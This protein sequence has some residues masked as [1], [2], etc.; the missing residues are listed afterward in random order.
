MNGRSLTA[1]LVKFL[2]FVLVTVLATGVLLLTIAN[3]SF[4]P[5]QTY[6]ARFTDVT[7][8]AEGDDVRI[9]G[10][11]VGEVNGIRV[12]EHRLAEVSFTVSE[13]R[14]PSSVTAA[15][16][17]RNLIGQRYVSLEQ[18]AGAVDEYL[19]PGK[20]IPVERTKP[21]LDLNVLL[22]GFKPLFQALSPKDVNTL[23]FEIIQVLQ[24][25][26]GTVE[27]L[28]AHTA[29]LTK[30]IAAKDEVIGQV[31]GNL[32]KVLETVNARDQELTGLV[33]QLQELVSGLAEDRDS[34]GGAISAL[35][36][37][38]NTTAGLLTEARPPLRQDIAGLR[39]L[40]ENL[41]RHEPV[42][43]EFLRDTPGKLTT[44]TRTASYGSWFNLYLCEASGTVGVGELTLP[45][46]LVPA[47]Q[48]RCRS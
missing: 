12:V 30:T 39:E 48:P 47:T 34:I 25:E 42:V 15:V 22:G 13:R 31:V 45:I 1:P 35:D 20:T 2:V 43:E 10:V 41:N 21:P 14:L 44:V 26:S 27:S 37:L 16:K 46:P 18:G 17:W 7:G 32:N 11:K 28:L 9:S 5:S 4:R 19:R 23:S 33:V 8:L 29:S 3:E 36:G 40:S 38:T 6:S 24:G